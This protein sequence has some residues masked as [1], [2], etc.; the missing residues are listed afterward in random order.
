MKKKS[1][2]LF[3]LAV[4]LILAT[5]ISGTLAYFTTYAQAEGG[6]KIELGYNTEM[7]EE[8]SAWTKHVVITNKEGSQPVYVR[9]AAFSGSAYD[10]LY[11]DDSGLWTLGDDGY[12]YYNEILYGGES[13]DEL[14]IR[15]ENIPADVL[16]GDSFNVVV[17]YETVPVLYDEDGKPYADWSVTLDSGSTSGEG[18]NN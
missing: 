12:H 13:T 8:F 15:I 14:L 17:I 16:D 10:L 11:S 9:V 1:I 7:H 3:A 18:G 4:V 6:Y 2:F 5:S